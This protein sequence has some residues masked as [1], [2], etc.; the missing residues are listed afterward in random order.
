MLRVRNVRAGYGTLEVVKGVSFH[1]AQGEIVALIGA[2]GAGKTSLLRALVG[3]LP[4][5]SGQIWIGSRDTTALEPWRAVSTGTVL[6]PEGRQLFAD[7]TVMDNL[8]MGGY[9]N[10]DRGLLIDEMLER[11]PRLRERSRQLAG[12]LS[13]GEQQMVA[14]AR[15]LVSRPSLLLLDE[16]SL[17]LAP[18]VV[19]EVFHAVRGLKELG[20]TVLMVEQNAIGALKIADRGYVMETGEITLEGSSVDLLENPEVKRAYLGKGYREVWE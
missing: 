1:V 5:W 13:G 10:P 18:L 12:T 20:V 9:H 19:E 17:G 11:F 2:N 3:L 14:L 16:P 6:I 8:L 7:M 4:P 15:G